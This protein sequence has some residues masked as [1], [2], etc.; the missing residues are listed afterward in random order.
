MGYFTPV[1]ARYLRQ[2][3]PYAQGRLLDVGCGSKPYR[4]IFVHATE[5]VGVDRPSEVDQCRGDAVERQRQIDL[6]G[7]ADHLPVGDAS[8]DTILCTQV[9][10][11]LPAPADFFKEA[12]RVLRPGGHLI[13]TAPL[14]NPV[15]EAPFD[16]YRYTEFGL[17]QLCASCA[18]SVVEL[19][20]MGGGWL[21]IG[22]LLRHLLLARAA[23]RQGLGRWWMTRLGLRLYGGC[24]WLDHRDPHLDTPL[25]YLLVARKT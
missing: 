12:A 24:D 20:P 14:I 25:N 1:I 9:I 3:E 6:V 8:F 16:F 5:Y 13:L 19:Q 22:Y 10:D 4:P 15:H 21:A 18:L 23:R 2:V 17:R 11:H 7:S